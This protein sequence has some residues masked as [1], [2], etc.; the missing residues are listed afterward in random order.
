[1]KQLSPVYKVVTFPD[2]L[3][4]SFFLSIINISTT[5]HK[6]KLKTNYFCNKIVLPESKKD[7]IVENIPFFKVNNFF[8]NIVY[9]YVCHYVRFK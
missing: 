7:I 1:M 2:N 5:T 8:R 4:V 6:F 9:K 3:F